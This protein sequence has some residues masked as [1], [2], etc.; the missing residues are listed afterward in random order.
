VVR[1]LALLLGVFALAV[2]ALSS[3][4]VAAAPA[5]PTAAPVATRVAALAAA[6]A[7]PFAARGSVEQ[8]AVTGALPGAP[9]ALVS[10]T[11]RTVARGTTDTAGAHIFR[12]VAPG[13]GYV[14][15]T[16]LRKTAPV[17]VMAP[18]DTPPASFYSAQRIGPGFGYLTTRDGTTLSISVTLPGPVDR[19]PY[20]TVVEY[21]GYD[22]SNP[23]GRQPASTVAQLL[24]YA[25]VGVNLRGTGCS[26]GA[27]RYFE[28]LQ[29]LDGYDTVEAVAAQPWVANGEVGM[30]G[31]SYPGI[32][33]LFVAATRPPHLEAIAPLSVIDDT[34]QTLYPGGIF[35]R[36]FAGTWAH[37][38]AADAAPEGQQWAAKRIK[39][40][41]TTCAANQALRL[42]APDVNQEI[43]SYRYVDGARSDAIAPATFVNRIEAPVFLAGAWQDEQTGAHFADMLDDF[44]PGVPV[45]FTLMNGVHADSLG[46]A[47]VARWAEFLDFYVA[48]RI[49]RVPNDVRS[50]ANQLLAQYYGPGVVLPPDRFTSFTDYP[51]ALAAY[52]QEP[53]I[54]VLFGVGAAGAPRSPVPAFEASFSSWPPPATQPTTWYVGADDTLTST[55]PTSTRGVDTYSYDP[56][57]YPPTVK[58]R[59]G[60][61]GAIESFVSAPS[62]DWKPLPKGTA[63]S[64]VTAPLTADTV[65]L[66]TG[67][68]DLW[69]RTSAP[70]VDF[71][72]TISEVRADGNETY[73]QS[74]WLR[75][76]ARKLDPATSTS[77]LPVPTYARADRVRLPAGTPTL[78]RVPLFPFGH[79]FRAGSRIRIVVQPP[80]GNRP[81]WSFATVKYRTPPTVG[82]LHTKTTP[83]KVVLPVVPGVAQPMPAAACDSLR[84]QPCRPYSAS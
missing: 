70:D 40:G 38:R 72:V 82:I 78:V 67:S 77:L 9:I 3:P 17:T 21:S 59:A 68:V 80:G 58:S 30:V 47:V 15:A 71:E 27:W 5:T 81:S 79:E 63:A 55:P 14:V 4:A 13:T 44:A 60:G 28:T 41:D 50:L 34:Y 54:R 2:G 48:R 18:T 19:G 7:G 6:A 51:S 11:G 39:N 46:P 56:R 35:N 64:F 75:A 84:G 31:I 45:K 23:D 25:T 24:G 29:S 10:A 57:A 20:P 8:V 62:F 22:A 83:S 76:S 66:G 53:P 43:R 61:S 74:G 16:A 36:G 37:D 42:Q 26:G 49:P 73:V 65:M 52:Q 32:T 69:V 1:R 12:D 33:Q